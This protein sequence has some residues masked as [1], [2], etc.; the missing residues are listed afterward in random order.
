MKPRPRK[1]FA[2]H[3]LEPPWVDKLVKAIAPGPLDQFLEIGPGH[4]A[5]TLKLAP[6]VAYVTAI[7][8]DRDLIAS[9]TPRL[10]PNVTLVQGD[11]LDTDLAGLLS[12]PQFA[13]DPQAPGHAES[14]PA[15]LT[16]RIAGNLPYSISSPILVRLLELASHQPVRDATLM[17]QREVVDRIVAKP[18][19]PEYGVL[20]VLT[21][22][23]TD[24]S[25]L[26][27]LPPGAFRPPPAVT[28]AVVRLSFRPPVI[29]VVSPAVFERLVRT[30][31]TQRRKTMSNALVPFARETS[32]TAPDALRRASIDPMRRPQT[33]QIVEIARLADIFAA[34]SR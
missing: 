23:K 34:S 17:L 16:L 28:S 4:G 19:S 18:G 25:K 12:L 30:I 29:P 8:I 3:F 10:P 33:L 24:V 26:M 11:V 15:Y 22:W 13:G 6:R 32:L 2:Q 7:E 21:Q 14:N 5:L 9:L 20:S 27:T 1:R 31:F